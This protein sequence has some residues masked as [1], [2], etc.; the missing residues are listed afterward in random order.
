[1]LRFLTDE[2]QEAEDAGQRV[3][4]MGH[5]PAGYDGGNPVINSPNLFYSIVQRYSPATIAN[6][7]FGHNHR[8]QFSLYYSYPPDKNGAFFAPGAFNTSTPLMTAWHSQ[9]LTSIGGLNG[10]WRYYDVDAET[11]T[12][13]DSHN[14]YADISVAVDDI[15]VQWQFLYSARETYDP[16]NTWPSTAPLNATFWDRLTKTITPDLLN[17]YNFYETRASPLTP[18]CNSTACQSQKI[19]YMR[20][21]SAYLGLQCGNKAGPN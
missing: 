19:C 21:G 9:S 3:W 5:V 12:I 8:D 6:I 18:N 20:S 17:Q 1:M 11:F 14:F 13:Y 10:G 16:N 4:I 7:F 15:P 2:L